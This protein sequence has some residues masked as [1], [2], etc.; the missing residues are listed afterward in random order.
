V[1]LMRRRNAEDYCEEAMWLWERRTRFV[2][3]DAARLGRARRKDQALRAKYYPAALA[4]ADKAIGIAPEHAKAH[5]LRGRALSELGRHEEALDASRQA[6]KLDPAMACVHYQVAVELHHL[7]QHAGALEAT[8]TAIGLDPGDTAP[9]ILRGMILFDQGRYTDALDAFTSVLQRRPDLGQVRFNRAQVLRA[10]GR[11]LEALADYNQALRL[12]PRSLTAL[13]QKAI[14]LAMMGQY[15]DAA[16]EFGA[17]AAAAGGRSTAR[18]NVW[19][20]AITWHGGD[21]LEARHLWKLASG[22]PVAANRWESV[23][24]R[25]VML[26]P[27][28]KAGTRRLFWELSGEKPM[29]ANRWESVNT[30][31]VVSCALGDTESAAGLLRLHSNSN[32]EDPATREVLSRLY[33][34]LSDPP[35]PG[36]DQLRAL[37]L[38][39]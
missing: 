29:G 9:F 37:A 34:L 11:Y 12:V 7:D 30:Q 3:A 33:D 23:N 21:P 36:I 16:A 13:E 4:A 18:S 19:E 6:V 22:K 1:A 27:D 35:M 17:A 39:S 32:T 25:A 28:E 20:A 15:D 10:L 14:T 8:D 38:G 2:P 5:Q 26:L 31:A 24:V